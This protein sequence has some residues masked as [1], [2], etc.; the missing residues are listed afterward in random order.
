MLKHTRL[1]LATLALAWVSAQGADAD[2]KTAISN[3][4]Q[5]LSTQSTFQWK[6][7]TH[8]EGGD[9]A[10]SGGSST[11]GRV[12]HPGYFWVTING[13]GGASEFV[14][15]GEY[16]AV[17]LDGDWMTPDQA[18]MRVAGGRFNANAIRNLK[19]P[20][21][22]VESLLANATHLKQEG[23]TISGEL[24][25]ETVTKLLGDDSSVGGT[26][27][28][29]GR[30]G[31]GNQSVQYKDAKG[32][33]SFAV[34]DGT[35]AQVSVA[36]S[37]VRENA[38]ANE[39]QS[40]T[41]TTDISNLDANTALP[42]DAQEIVDALAA[43]R[44]PKVFV[45]EPGFKKLFNGHDLTG[46][47][48]RMEHWT[49]KDGAITGSTTK[50]NPA[51]GNN[52]LIAKS[53][54]TNLVVDDFELRFLYRIVADNTVGF[55]NS[56]VQYRSKDLGNFVVGGYQAD[57]EAGSS[58]SGILY[59]EAGGAGGRGIMAQR[60]ELVTWNLDGSHAV[61]GHLGKSED[62]QAHIKQNDWNEYVIVVQGK[63][64]QHFING[65]QTVGV[66]DET[67]GKRLASGI[68]ALQL[69]AGEPMT[70][71]YKNI[72]IKHLG[73][74][75]VIGGSNIRI[76]KGFKIDQ[77]Y[78]VPKE[79]EGSWVAMCLDPKGRLIVSDQNGALH[80]VTL[81]EGDGGA[82]K[83]ET[84]KLDVGGA[85]GLLYAFDSLYVAVNEGSR[86]HGVYRLR[87]TDGDDQFDKVEL[88]RQ[89]QASGEHGLHSLVLSPDGKS[90]YVV[91]GNQSTLTE[92]ESS[93]V[94][95]DW[96]EDDLLP[97]L[98]TGFMDDSYAPQ[99]YISR[100]DPDGKHWEL[101]AAGLRNEFDVAF[102]KVGELFT[103]DA[104]MEW[105]I[106]SPWYRPTRVNH[107]ISGAEYGFRN[108][109]EKWPDYY[110]DSFGAAVN[111]GPGSP[112]GIA[113][114]Y[115][116]KFPA[117]YQDALFL[118][119]WSFGKLRA[120]HLTPDGASYTGESEEFISGQPFPVTDFVINPRDGSMLL[121]VGGRGAQSA[122]YRVTYIGGES[123]APNPPD[124]RLQAQRD[125][126][127][128]LEAFHGRKDP[129]AIETVWP[130]LSDQD[131]S[132]RYAA[133]IAVEWQDPAQWTEKALTEKDPRKMIAALAALARVS[134]R[135]AIHHKNTDPAPDPTLRTRILAALDG[136]DWA[137]LAA[138]DRV[139]LLR[140]YS[141]ALIRLGKPDE[142]TRQ[143][144]IARLDP[145]FPANRPDVDALLARLL[146]FTEAP[147][148]ATKVV[149]ALRTAPT[150]EGQIDLAVSLR[151][152]KGGWTPE[153]REEYFRWF[154]TAEAYR[155]GN[156]FASSIR[157]AKE[158]ALKLLSEGERAA[159]KPI[160]ETKSVKKSPRDA[161]AARPQIK[162]WKLAELVPLVEAGIK[163]GR[164]FERGR[165]LF[166][167]VACATCHRFVNEGGSVG[168]EL[169]GVVGR[170]SVHDLLESI[171]DPSKVISDQYAAINILKKD[172]DTVSGR[173]GNLNAATLN[174]V[175]DMFDPGNMTSVRRSDIASMEPSTVS[176]MPEGLLNS[177]KA[178]EVQDLIAYLLSRGDA[179]NP[180]FQ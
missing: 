80:R 109:N 100:M 116:A 171:V 156:T 15:H 6:T 30:G 152:L 145:L 68:L 115:G 11:L 138:T 178:E 112:T 50:D 105:D 85:H 17:D 43:G 125:L 149:A 148:A 32:T 162:E 161:L 143:Q 140:T 18:A 45:P 3:A 7:D 31:R 107:V 95:Y 102:N 71:Q 13:P 25:P 136:L 154:N 108:G 73:T 114:G 23:T 92:M 147:S 14:R 16:A 142:A 151:S 77:L 128:K 120:V 131:R 90:I 63:R 35:L 126:R 86:P 174:I 84:I 34:R 144:L 163:G 49:V 19:S 38:K 41:L 24:N 2:L 123:T 1:L 170:F 9:P 72:Q 65:M 87:D 40:R 4:A 179:Q 55:A 53:G 111:I 133:R 60:G 51:K 29:S 12:T 124:T 22:Q 159:L 10:G 82:V 168:P 146:I 119:D 70:V 165:Q 66:I 52:F 62:I 134:G 26:F 141:L 177:L 21:A 150:Q 46:W 160:L 139:D 8:S 89:V 166:G 47:A 135:D 54:A 57:M 36:L 129:A 93:R 104:D 169:T 67:D 127:H 164:N 76:A 64:I 39:R 74:P 158:D 96:S 78:T 20:E 110:F 175:E 37:G 88:L 91:I 28:A 33:V 42:A 157:R 103:Y 132:L 97:R 79:T 121:A 44:A 101:I 69:H 153:L 58:Y 117:K 5:K 56:G 122:L 137:K 118:A 75:D 99:G 155:G 81:P 130:Y 48:G 113:F 167:A 180:M 106:G 98:P 61:T 173:V 27:R 172:G 176:M 94:P 83:T 59:D